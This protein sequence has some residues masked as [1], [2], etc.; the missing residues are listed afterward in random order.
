MK[1]LKTLNIYYKALLLV[2]YI[3]ANYYGFKYGF[4]AL[5]YP[6]DITFM[7]GLLGVVFLIVTDVLI[8][9]SVVRHYFNEN[10][11]EI[12]LQ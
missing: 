7:A 5:N 12:P 6:K 9:T 4:A 11:K 1:I 10:E 8:I 3:V 2:L